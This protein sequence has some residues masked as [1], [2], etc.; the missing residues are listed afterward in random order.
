[1]RVDVDEVDHDDDLVLTYRGEPFTGEVVEH[2]R[3]GAVTS[4]IN[5]VDGIEHGSSRFWYPDGTLQS[6]ATAR[7]GVAVGVARDWY[8]NGKLAIERTFDDDGVLVEIKRWGE[9]G[10]EMR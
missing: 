9:D 2:G 4:S 1:M 7:R 3:D 10:V 6:E 8:S 5:Y